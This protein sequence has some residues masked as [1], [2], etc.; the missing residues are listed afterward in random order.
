MLR[1]FDVL[2][3][4]GRT[5]KAFPRTPRYEHE[6]LA[7]MDRYDVDRAL[8]FHTVSR[9]SDPEQGNEALGS[10]T[11]P[12]LSPVWGFDPAFLI[13][14]SAEA[15]LGRAVAGGAKGVMVNP[16]MR[17]ILLGRSPRVMDLASAM[18]RRR[19]PLVLAYWRT[20]P[21]DDVIDWYALSDFCRSYPSLPVIA[22][23]WRAR[24]NRPLFDALAATANL[25]IVLSSLWQAQSLDAICHRFGP[26][27]LLFSLGL[28]GLDPGS[29]QACVRYADV[30]EEAKR[31]VAGE[32]LETILDNADYQGPWAS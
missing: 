21:E 20:N 26:E 25:R 9:D 32:N 2:F 17:N 10:L 11:S 16:C 15:F 4:L 18:A 7:L 8:V 28:P 5:N 14:E 12:R 27:R 23:E 29:F 31:A 30:P 19:I 6:A 24:S 1:F 13:A 22:W 3:P